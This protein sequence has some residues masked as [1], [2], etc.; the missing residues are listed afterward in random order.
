[1]D[2]VLVLGNGIS[3]LGF[4][5]LIREWPGEVW[6]CNRAYLEYGAKLSR[7]TGHTDVLADAA[8]YQ[9][10]HAEARFELWAGNLGKLIDGAKPFTCPPKFRHDSGT[11]MIAQALEER[12]SIACVGFDLG[13]WDVSSPGL[14]NYDKSEWVQRWRLIASHYGLAHVRFIGFDHKPFILSDKPADTYARDYKYGIP[15]IDDPE[16]L[17]EWK[18]WT[19]RDPAGIPRSSIMVKVKFPNGY[20]GEMRENIAAIM[21]KRGELK[22]ISEASSR[23]EMTGSASFVQLKKK[24]AKK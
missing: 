15:H 4:D 8:R 19:G 11:T 10:Q 1:M 22:I 13:G 24:A 17:A 21:E 23:R 2:E 6:G 7:L 9:D 5:K 16:Y 3:R 12:R 20:E 14:E 18:K